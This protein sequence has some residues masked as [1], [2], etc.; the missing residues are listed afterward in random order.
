MQGLVAR[1]VDVPLKAE[2]ADV[3]DDES[4][5]AIQAEFGFIAFDRLPDGF[6]N[7]FEILFVRSGLTL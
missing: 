3:L 1:D 6:D 7:G 2:G 4:M 5:Q